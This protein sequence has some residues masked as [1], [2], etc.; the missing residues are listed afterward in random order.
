MAVAAFKPLRVENRPLTWREFEFAM[1][2][3]RLPFHAAYLV[4]AK[5]TRFRRHGLV[6]PKRYVDYWRERYDLENGQLYCFSWFVSKGIWDFL[7]EEE[8][9]EILTALNIYPMMKIRK[10]G[11]IEIPSHLVP[12][13]RRFLG[14]YAPFI[15]VTRRFVHWVD[16]VRQMRHIED[17]GFK[18]GLQVEDNLYYMCSDE[19]FIRQTVGYSRMYY[20]P[21]FIDFL[22]M[23]DEALLSC[24]RKITCSP[25]IQA[26]WYQIIFTWAEI[27]VPP[28]LRP[29]RRARGVILF[30]RQKIS[31]GW[32]WV[33]EA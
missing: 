5:I 7:R 9:T 18:I 1:A 29:R 28:F 19:W 17:I 27:A 33:G 30:P 22:I 12:F 8:A 24:W 4:F 21:S 26:H 32:L 2:T 14:G 6:I 10:D 31:L 11:R 25:R 3:R 15:I 16:A 13:Y 20:R 23:V